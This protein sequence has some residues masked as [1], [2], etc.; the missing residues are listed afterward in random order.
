MRAFSILAVLAFS[1][2]GVELLT[3]TAIQGELQ[4][5][6]M[7]ALKGQVEH[8]A[9]TSGQVNLQRAI[10]T[11]RAETGVNPPSLEALVPNYIAQIPV[12]A[13]GAPYGYDPSTGRLLTGAGAASAASEQ[14]TLQEIRAAINRYGTAT[15][16]YPPTLD[17]LVPNYLPAPPRTSSG[18][19]FL[20]NNQNGYVDVPPVAAGSAAPRGA[21]A[22]R[23]MPVGG[24][25]M[26]EVMTGIGMQQ[27]LGSQS[28]AGSASAGTRMREQTG[29]ATGDHNARQNQ[30]M[31]D[32]GL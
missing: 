13:G 27:Q 10:D 15:G 30:I 9:G 4:A 28:H 19:P 2:C 5:Q 7:K 17:A 8:A 29:V 3:T 14:Q 11:Y 26:G 23:G 32:L 31:N 25:P 1:G 21:P 6:Q 24:G 22:G 18:Q 12:Q 16:Y 20:Y